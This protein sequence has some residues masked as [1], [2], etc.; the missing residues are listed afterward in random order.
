M[1][2]KMTLPDIYYFAFLLLGGFFVPLLGVVAWRGS[3][4]KYAFYNS[5]NIFSCCV[6]YYL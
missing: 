6:A 4:K 1:S 2:N 5:Q 3:V